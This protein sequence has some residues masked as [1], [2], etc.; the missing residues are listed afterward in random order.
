MREGR[1]DLADHIRKKI[2]KFIKKELNA[3][4]FDICSYAESL[5]DYGNYFEA[6]LFFQITLILINMEKIDNHVKTFKVSID[7]IHGFAV[8]SLRL[9]KKQLSRQIL[10]KTTMLPWIN[11]ALN[12]AEKACKNKKTFS[13]AQAFAICFQSRILFRLKELPDSG[14]LLKQTI[15]VLDDCHL[16]DAP[17]YAIFAICQFNFWV[18]AFASG[19]EHVDIREFAC[20]AILNMYKAQDLDPFLKCKMIRMM[21]VTIHATRLATESS[22]A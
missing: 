21:C 10:L 12:V 11:K 16:L 7:C 20:L 3:S 8:S 1:G 14:V 2:L 19:Y 5:I 18:L 17:R 13:L 22:S 4:A 9:Y 15:N 6:I